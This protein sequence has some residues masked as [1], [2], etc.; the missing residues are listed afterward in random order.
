[1]MKKNHLFQVTTFSF[2]AI[3]LIS[4]IALDIIYAGAGNDQYKPVSKIGYQI[5]NA[6]LRS[7]KFILDIFLFSMFL[8]LYLFFFGMMRAKRSNE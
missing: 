4:I 6:I 7:F 2:L 8:N 3:Y 5:F 1:M